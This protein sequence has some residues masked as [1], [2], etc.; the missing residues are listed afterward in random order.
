[1][2]VSQSLPAV[3]MPCKKCG[4]IT[5]REELEAALLPQR[6]ERLQ[7]ENLEL[8]KRL[9]IAE[10]KSKGWAITYGRDLV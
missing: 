2:A 5:T 3:G 10:A 9:T 1:M 8:L 4:H 7:K 6:M